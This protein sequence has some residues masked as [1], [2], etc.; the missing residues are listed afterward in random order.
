MYQSDERFIW[1]RVCSSLQVSY[2]GTPYGVP[3]LR[4]SSCDLPRA[5]HS[6]AGVLERPE[7]SALASPAIPA[8]GSTTG[9]SSDVGDKHVTLGNISTKVCLCAL[10]L[11]LHL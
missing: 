7:R 10:R 2:E 8:M 4:P 6:D 5:Y 11:H 9:V 1:S 3:D